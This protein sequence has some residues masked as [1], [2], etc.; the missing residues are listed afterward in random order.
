MLF[1]LAVTEGVGYKAGDKRRGYNRDFID[2]RRAYFHA[3]ARGTVYVKLPP[4]DTEP[5]MCGIFD[6]ALHG[7]RYAAQTWVSEQRDLRVV[8]HGDDFTNLGSA[9]ELDWF[10]GISARF[11]AKFRG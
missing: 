1:S 11:E 9:K 2:V 7:T 4:E 3:R 10:R 6:K 5:G 8:V